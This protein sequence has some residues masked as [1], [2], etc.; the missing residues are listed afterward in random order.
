[1]AGRHMASTGSQEAA[2]EPAHESSQQSQ[3]ESA[4]NVHYKISPTFSARL[5]RLGPREKIRAL[6]LPAQ[7]PLSD[8]DE[9]LSR[10]ACREDAAAS[11]AAQSD[12]VYTAIDSRLDADG[13]RRL[14]QNPN[15]LGFVLVEA[16]A[17]AL[18]RLAAL[19]CVSAILE[20][21]PLHLIRP[22][23]ELPSGH[24][25]SPPAAF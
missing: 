22:A 15:R 2:H 13:G 1:M 23:G 11:V 4:A 7:P 21:Q 6:V 16:T 14:S 18:H 19:E 24:G 9:N 10:A 5:A 8:R 25:E 17:M 12:A 3:Q 20:D